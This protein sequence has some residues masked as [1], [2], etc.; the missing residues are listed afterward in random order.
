M[1][2]RNI[3]LVSAVAIGFFCLAILGWNSTA[4]AAPGDKAAAPGDKAAASGETV[5][6]SDAGGSDSAAQEDTKKSDDSRWSAEE[7]KKK[8]EELRKLK[9][10]IE[11]LEAELE[12]GGRGTEPG[13]TEEPPTSGIPIAPAD[14]V[15]IEGTP[16]PAM[17]VAPTG[18]PTQG[19]GQGQGS[20]LSPTDQGPL[21]PTAFGP[22]DGFQRGPSMMTPGILPGEQPPM[23]TGSEGMLGQSF[24]PGGPG[25]MAPPTSNPGASGGAASMDPAFG[26]YA[27]FAVPQAMG[28]LGTSGKPQPVG[29]ATKDKPFSNY[30]APRAISPYQN[31]YREPM[32]GVDNYNA[33][34][35]PIMEQQRVNVQ[36]QYE[37]SKLQRTSRTQTS[38]IQ[39]LD[40]RLNPYQ[41]QLSQPTTQQGPAQFMNL[42]QY[43]PGLS[44]RR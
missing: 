27:S 20:F 23:T 6:K 31:L 25:I 36:T 16:A 12:R 26:R 22:Q 14:E 10:Q 4:Q 17:P 8:L 9:E 5:A 37:V 35:K 41:R 7:R 33:Y 1:K 42:Q 29:A 38:N 24:G 18:Q 11:K 44:R 40:Q 3:T 2:S 15:Q 32:S 19:V 43:Y 28:Q 13:R 21:P 30:T 39:M 34:V